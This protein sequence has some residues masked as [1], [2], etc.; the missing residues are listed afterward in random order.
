M[1]QNFKTS[2]NNIRVHGR[3][4][5]LGVVTTRKI[6]PSIKNESFFVYKS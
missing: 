2:P 4:T 3:W 1:F 6:Y 5:Y